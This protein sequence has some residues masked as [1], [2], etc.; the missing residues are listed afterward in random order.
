MSDPISEYI[1]QSP[2]KTRGKLNQLRS[3][4]LEV[5]PTLEECLSYRMPTFKKNG[6][7]VFHFAVHKN[8]VGLYPTPGPI[9]KFAQRLSVY[10]T[11]KGSVQIPFDQPLDKALIQD[12]LRF[13]LD[14]IQAGKSI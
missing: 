2:K 11:S 6:K 4:L 3:I 5:D 10:K 13:N 12:M 1:N 8:H 7:N 14:Q 9:E